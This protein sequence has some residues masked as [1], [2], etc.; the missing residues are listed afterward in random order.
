MR[1]WE[2]AK[3]S[4]KKLSPPSPSLLIRVGEGPVPDRAAIMI[5][6]E[7]V[8]DAV[9]VEIEIIGREGASGEGRAGF[10]AVPY[11]EDVQGKGKKIIGRGAGDIGKLM[12]LEDN[13]LNGGR[14]SWVIH[15][16]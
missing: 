12:R 15:A 14:P 8:L 10:F 1:V 3:P 2:K 6:A 11:R 9:A 7:M 16:V 13:F 5:G 4:S